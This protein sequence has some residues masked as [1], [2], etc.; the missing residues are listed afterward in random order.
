[1]GHLPRCVRKGAKTCINSTRGETQFRSA[2]P[3]VADGLD[4]PPGCRYAPRFSQGAF[5][6]LIRGQHSFHSP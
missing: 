4:H 6:Q 5:W 2:V 1:V 3:G